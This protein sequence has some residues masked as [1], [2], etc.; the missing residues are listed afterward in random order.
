[1][2]RPRDRNTHEQPN[3]REGTDQN[4]YDRGMEVVDGNRRGDRESDNPTNERTPATLT[5]EPLQLRQRSDRHP[6]SDDAS[7]HRSGKEPRLPVGV[8]QYGTDDRTEPC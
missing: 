4:G 8:P 1:M 7:D 5:G 2:C 3:S 6:D